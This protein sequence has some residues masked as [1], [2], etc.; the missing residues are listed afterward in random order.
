MMKKG[1]VVGIICL[2]MLISFPTVVSSEGKPDL[3]IEDMIIMPGHFPD[4]QE[5]FFVE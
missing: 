3:I 1:L 2:L 5:F 4:E